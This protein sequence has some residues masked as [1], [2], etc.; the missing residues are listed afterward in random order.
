[1]VD[2]NFFKGSGKSV[3][4]F[5]K[6]LQNFEGEGRDFLF[7]AKV[8]GSMSRKTEGKEKQKRKKANEVLGEEFY[9]ELLDKRGN[10]TRQNYI[11][12]FW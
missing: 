11:W 6:A 1:M 10:K 5:K 8:Y 9:E 2:F 3:G 4:D 12:I 7:D